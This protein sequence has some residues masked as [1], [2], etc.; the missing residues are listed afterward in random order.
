MG[1]G[2]VASAG[3][4][5]PRGEALLERILGR[6]CVRG[7]EEGRRPLGSPQVSRASLWGTFCFTAA[8]GGGQS[9]LS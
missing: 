1:S 5:V 7:G 9:A 6:G 2:Q 4:Q 3:L 8:P